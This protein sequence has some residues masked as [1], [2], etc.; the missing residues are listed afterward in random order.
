MISPT[1]ETVADVRR[2]W[3]GDPARYEDLFDRIGDISREAR[4]IIISGNPD[5]LGSL[6]NQ[7]QTLLKE[8]G[9]SSE[10]LENFVETA[11]ASGALGAKL[12][13]GGRGGNIIALVA[14][15][16][17]TFVADALKRAGAERVFTTRIL[18]N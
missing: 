1:A 13:G 16:S 12:S 18:S 15:D 14:E 9:V 3:E 2:G 8:I 11:M 7:N 17:T 5:S 6:M 10:T 4:E